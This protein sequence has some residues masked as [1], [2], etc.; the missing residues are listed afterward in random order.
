M[1]KGRNSAAA[2]CVALLALATTAM[3]Q[4][5]GFQASV[6]PNPVGVGEQFTLTLVLNNAGMG[7]GKNLK[8]PDLGKFHIMAGPNQS[9]S[10]QMINGS[11]S[12]SVTYSYVLQPKEMGKFTI[13]AVTIEAGGAVYTTQ[14]IALEVVKSSGKQ[15]QQAAVPNDAT[16]QIG[17]NLFLRASVDKTHVMQGE[18]VNLVFK[19]YT[20]VSVINYAVDKNPALTGFWS[21]DVETPKNIALSNETVNGKQ[22]RVGVI[23]KM[24]LFPTQSGT[25]EISP[26]EVQATVQVQSGRSY[27]PFESFFRDPFGRNVNYAVKSEAVKIKVDP[28]PSGA[29]PDFKGAV[30]QF[31][32]S[33]TVDKKTTRTNEPIDLKVTVSGTGNI[34]LLEPPAVELPAD[35]EQYTP[36]V[37]DN[38]NRQGEK[39][40]GS[41]TFGYLLIPRYPGL[42]VIKPVTFSYFDIGKKE[43]A[44][45]RSPQIELNVEQGSAVALPLAGVGSRE[46]VRMLSQDIRFIKVSGASFVRAGSTPFGGLFVLLVLLPLAGVAGAFV[47]ARKRRA[48]MLDEAGYRNRRAIRVAQKGL[49]QAE[50]LLKQKGGPQASPAAN[51]RL[52]F[53]TEISRAL[54]KYLADKLAILQAEF[55][56]DGACNEL[57]R[58]SVPEGL[59]RSLRALLESCDLAR[60]APT[61]LETA[62]MQKTYDEARRVIVELERTLK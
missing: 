51:Q 42:K 24:A 15:K 59:V 54:W 41:K 61:S 19:L 6:E 26:M 34:K 37:S 56:V 38:I 4:G 49:K 28:L 13:G 20:R 16:V 31:A 32:M 50:Y 17:D 46:D 21:E 55:S 14:P 35:F 47:Y 57:A 27:D 58:R 33:T 2:V 5:I 52:R 22:Y 23:K 44:K 36:K 62:A 48:E 7:G 45:L 1:N 25:L 40:A 60:F 43:Y 39:I 12:S 30:G 10:M 18:Q 8:L 11:V 3:G 9:T 53:Y 29:P